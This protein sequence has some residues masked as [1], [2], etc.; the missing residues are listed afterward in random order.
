MQTF[1]ESERR[2]II[3]IGADSNGKKRGG[4]SVG[5]RLQVV[6]TKGCKWTETSH[7]AAK[8]QFREGGGGRRGRGREA[9]KLGE[10][11]KGVRT[12]KERDERS[13]KVG[14]S[15]ACYEPVV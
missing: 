9:V 14:F 15:I 3:L 2:L 5:N 6:E 11:R 10:A 7:A 12:E 4:S 1:C 8:W 13:V